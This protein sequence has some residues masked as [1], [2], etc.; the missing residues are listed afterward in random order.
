MSRIL[1]GIPTN[2]LTCQ[3]NETKHNRCPQH[4]DESRKNCVKSLINPKNKHKSHKNLFEKLSKVYETPLTPQLTLRIPLLAIDA[5]RLTIFEMRNSPEN[6]LFDSAETG[7]PRLPLLVWI[8]KFLCLSQT[9]WF[10]FADVMKKNNWGCGYEGVS[11]GIFHIPT[12]II[13][14]SIAAAV[15]VFLFFT[16]STPLSLSASNISRDFV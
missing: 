3:K 5:R 2:W 11:A 1:G 13:R 12:L 14:A 8:F 10:L 16:T 15:V 4:V 7:A 6:N 9:T